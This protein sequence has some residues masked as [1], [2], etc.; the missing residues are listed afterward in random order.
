MTKDQKREY[1]REWY[2]KKAAKA[3]KP[4]SPGKKKGK[5]HAAPI[6]T[7]IPVFEAY[8]LLLKSTER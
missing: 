1:Q 3:K 4:L 5:V 6:A 8:H 7:L 2:K